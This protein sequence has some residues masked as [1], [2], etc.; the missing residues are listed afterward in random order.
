ML[1]EVDINPASDLAFEALTAVG[2]KLYDLGDGQHF[3]IFLLAIANSWAENFV[4]P[5]DHA[6]F[7]E[8]M[9]DHLTRLA[10]CARHGMN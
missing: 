3:T 1:D 9:A 10:A 7:F 6:A 8:I 5:E 4:P 2:D